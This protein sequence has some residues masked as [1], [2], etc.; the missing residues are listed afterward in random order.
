MTKKDRFEHIVRNGSTVHSNERR[1][2][3]LGMVMNKTGKDFL[4]SAGRTIHEHRHICCGNPLGQTQKIAA[5]DIAA[6]HIPRIR[7]QCCRKLQTVLISKCASGA[8][9]QGNPHQFATK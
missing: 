5:G 4:A 2:C 8:L 3:T 1:I 7:Q 9:R 6:R